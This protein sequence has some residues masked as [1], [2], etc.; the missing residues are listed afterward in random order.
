ML[1]N[2]TP[3]FLCWP[4]SGDLSDSLPSSL[5]DL[6]DT[7]ATLLLP[8]DDNTASGALRRTLVSHQYGGETCNLAH[9]F[10]VLL[11]RQMEALL[12]SSGSKGFVTLCL[13][14]H[15]MRL[16]SLLV[17]H[18]GAMAVVTGSDLTQSLLG[19]LKILLQQPSHRRRQ[20]LA[21]LQ[22]RSDRA[23]LSS[24]L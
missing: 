17:R 15:A 14:P 24:L 22:V 9:Q 1:C 21:A 8:S 18:A 20:Y 5:V 4:V 13:Q 7:A 16:S 2:S 6:M 3:S 19:Y 10:C 12:G 23:I 11:G